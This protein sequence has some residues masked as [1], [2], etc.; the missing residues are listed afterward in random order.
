VVPFTYAGLVSGRTTRG[1]RPDGS[2]EMEIESAA[3]YLQALSQA[4]IML[5]Q[6]ARRAAIVEQV[7]ALAAEVGGQV[8]DDPGLLEEV[9]YLVERPTALLGRFEKKYLGLPRDLLVMV[10]RKHQRYFPVVRKRGDSEIRYSGLGDADA[11]SRIHESTSLLPHFITIRNGGEA[12]MDIVRH[13]NQ[14][15][16]RARFADAEFFWKADT[17]KKLEEFSPRLN[18]LTFQEQLGSMLD[19]TRRL[20]RL[21]P[22]LCTMLGLSKEETR[23]AERAAQLCKA[24]LVTQMVIDFTALQGI[25]GREYALLSGEPA[26]AAL[27]IFEHYL[28]RFAGDAA[29]TTRPGLVLGLANRLDSLAGLFA[30]GLAPS[31]SADPYHLRRDALGL[32]HNLTAHRQP[33]SVREGLTLAAKLMPVPVEDAPLDET[34]AFVRERLRGVLRDEGYPFDVVD[35]VL[36]DRRGDDPYRA[37]VAVEQLAN[38][39]AR[40]DWPETLAAYSRCVRILRTAPEGLSL[41]AV[42]PGRFVEPATRALHAAYLEAADQ[43]S[44]APKGRYADSSVDELLTAFLPLVGPITIFFEEVLVMAE[45]EAL[46]TNRLALLQCIANLTEGIVDLSKLQGF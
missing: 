39:V 25:M 31:G 37:R 29:P 35:A 19:K 23:V 43:V 20:E 34:A 36:S 46:R 8:P 38:W 3:S 9:T 1:L 21:V 16:V 45:D 15:V 41:E 22:K 14:E 4:N 2:P 28:P 10:M 44:P 7:E 11:E 27:A 18:T 17:Q 5:D 32:V 33:F 30:V 24:D 26:E 42:D 13:G 6:N 12:H 40:D